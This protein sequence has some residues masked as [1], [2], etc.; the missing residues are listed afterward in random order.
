MKIS[1]IYFDFPFWRAEVARLS[2]FIGNIDFKDLRISSEE[3]QR[4]KNIGKLDNGIIVPFH[5]LPCLIIDNNS[6]AQT[7]GI[8]RL[9]GKLSNLYPSDN[10][11]EA[12]KIDQFIDII[13]DITVIIT[14]TKAKNR[15]QDFL[16]EVS[17]KLFILNKNIDIDSNYLVNNSLSVSDIALW[18]FT[19]WLTGGKVKGIPLNIIKKYKNISKICLSV[20]KHPKINEWIIKTYPKSYERNLS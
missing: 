13:T 20:D 14:S 15:K 19:C 6:I 7:G 4:V 8:A 1:F 9:C 3:F 17:R 11:I 12:A 10:G 18:S 2:L 16:D 5:Q